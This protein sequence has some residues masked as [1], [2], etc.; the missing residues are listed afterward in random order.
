MF[1]ELLFYCFWAMSWFGFAHT[2]HKYST[3]FRNYPHN[4]KNNIISFVHSILSVFLAGRYLTQTKHSANV[5]LYNQAFSN[6]SLMNVTTL[7]ESLADGGYNY[8]NMLEIYNNVADQ[9]SFTLLSL[10][11]MS[12]CYFV[13]D[14]IYIIQQGLIYKKAP[15]IFHHIMTLL[16]HYYTYTS[17]NSYEYVN[18]FYYGEL[19]NFFTYATYHFIKTNNE[20]M[21]YVSS[22]F[23]CVWF[24]IFR[25]FVYSYF[26]LHYIVFCSMDSMFMKFFLLGIYLMGLMWGYNLLNTTYESIEKRGH[27]ELAVK[28]L[29]NT[30]TYL[31]NTFDELVQVVNMLVKSVTG[32]GNT[33][34][35]TQETTSEIT[36]ETTPE[37]IPETTSEITTEP[38]PETISEM[39]TPVETDTIGTVTVDPLEDTRNYTL[40]RRP[41][42]VAQ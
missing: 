5:F 1:R 22:L 9:W 41:T 36:T 10:Q 4:V 6:T 16:L 15:Y 21:A 13:A 29:Y 26:L 32:R 23:Q 40:R 39:S 3:T 33:T 18:I 27:L 14:C 7:N 30:K 25:V 17:E 37:T 28:E 31:R 42:E 24:T 20:Q 11:A 38:T 34:E 12:V 35:T 8:V 19:S 2:L